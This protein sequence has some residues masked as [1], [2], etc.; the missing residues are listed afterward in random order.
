MLLLRHH[1]DLVCSVYH[2]ADPHLARKCAAKL[3]HSKQLSDTAKCKPCL[4]TTVMKGFTCQSIFLTAWCKNAASLTSLI[5]A[6]T[7]TSSSSQEQ[8]K[9]MLSLV[10]NSYLPSTNWGF[11]FCSAKKREPVFSENRKLYAELQLESTKCKWWPLLLTERK[12]TDP[13]L[14]PNRLVRVNM[15]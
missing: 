4:K 14:W 1:G 6:Y 5:S 15:K 9:H 7:G 13:S 12:G 11:S 3:H 2:Q 10:T 8:L